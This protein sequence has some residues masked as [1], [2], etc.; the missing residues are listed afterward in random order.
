MLP[1]CHN[2][3]VMV[4]MLDHNFLCLSREL[5]AEFDLLYLKKFL[6]DAGCCAL[7][8]IACADFYLE[9][10]DKIRSV[11]IEIITVW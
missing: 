3:P 9:V 6:K 10:A 5:K 1:A 4:A 11:R 2:V 7:V 8:S